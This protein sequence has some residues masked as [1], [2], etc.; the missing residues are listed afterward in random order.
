TRGK[1]ALLRFVER[2]VCRHADLVIT[3]SV[4]LKAIVH[5][6]G[7]P[8]EKI[9]VVYNAPSFPIVAGDKAQLRA[10]FNI[11][12]NDTLVVS[13]GR[14]VPWKGF[15]ALGRA[16]AELLVAGRNVRL[17]CIGITDEEL[18]AM[19]ADAEAPALPPTEPRI[20]GIGVANS[21][22]V[23]D[24]LR[25]ADAFVLNTAYE[26]LSH[27]ILEAMYAGV[28]VIT[29]AV[30]GNRE[31]IRDGETGVLIPYNDVEKI[32]QAV[33]LLVRDRNAYAPLARRAQEELKKFS[34]P[35]MLQATVERLERL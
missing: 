31:L 6:W 24:W 20:V 16:V 22:R 26:G 11:A 28:P 15:G 27:I 2:L 3:P 7:V 34:L 1:Y 30:G 33:A 14:P 5:G 23:F 13:V 19:M 9:S 17:V 35:V 21:T 32:K 10:Q 25:A 8:D 4:F 29:T 12:A 18:R